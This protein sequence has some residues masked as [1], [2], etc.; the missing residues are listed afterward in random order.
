MPTNCAGVA[1][2]YT[3]LM[4]HCTFSS[5]VAAHN[6][7]SSPFS[8]GTFTFALFCSGKGKRLMLLLY[9]VALPWGYNDIA[10]CCVKVKALLGGPKGKEAVAL[11]DDETIEK[12]LNE[13]EA[14]LNAGLNFKGKFNSGLQVRSSSSPYWASSTQVYRCAPLLHHH[15]F[16]ADTTLR[17]S[18]L[19]SYSQIQLRSTGALFVFTISSCLSPPDCSQASSDS[20]SQGSA[21]RCSQG[22]VSPAQVVQSQA[23][24]TQGRV[25]AEYSWKNSPDRVMHSG[26]SH[27]WW[28]VSKGNTSNQEALL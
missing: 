8:M 23:E 20:S 27:S 21:A 18:L 22:S 2:F 13:V 16:S 26:F 1:A 7:S 10:V 14:A 11:S 19:S 6:R 4:V 12:C 15:I 25:L 3:A 5:F 28:C 24:G 17:W 9:C